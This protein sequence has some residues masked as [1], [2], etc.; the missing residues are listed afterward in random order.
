M[1]KLSLPMKKLSLPALPRI[2]M[3]K[4]DLKA[5]AAEFRT[6]DPKDPGLWPLVPRVVILLG[7]F[8]CLLFFAFW[9][10]WRAHWSELE[11]KRQEEVRLKAEWLNKKRQAV[12]LDD[13]KNQLAEIERSFGA[14]LKQLPDATEMESLLV[15]IK[16]AG[17]GRGLQFELFK[18][19]STV[20]RD[21]YAE[22]PITINMTGSYHD[23]GAFAD[24][25][26]R[27][28]RIVT[29]N[30]VTIEPSGKTGNVLTMKTTARTFRY[31]SEEELAAQRRQAAAAKAKGRASQ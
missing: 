10:G 9:L 24:D 18:P 31:L 26:A 17:V 1:K 12:N 4:L 6:L 19:G 16:R 8:V 23:F 29:L 21:F 22:L 30:D 2:D 20:V 28:P 11:T 15:D 3:K 7:L 25:I 14:L 5:I 13:Y 27:L